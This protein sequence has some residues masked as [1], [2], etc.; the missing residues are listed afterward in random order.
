MKNDWLTLQLLA[1][2]AEVFAFVGLVS[3]MI[4]ARAA[5]DSKVLWRGGI[6]LVSWLNSGIHCIYNYYVYDI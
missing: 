2:F 4:F 1:S 3:L 6:A 5:D